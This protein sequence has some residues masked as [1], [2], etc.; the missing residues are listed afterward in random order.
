LAE[1]ETGQLAAFLIAD[2]CLVTAGEISYCTTG[3]RDPGFRREL[4]S[5][6]TAYIVSSRLRRLG[7]DTAAI[8]KVLRPVVLGTG[9]G[10]ASASGET[11]RHAELI[12]TVVFVMI[13]LFTVIGYGLRVM[14][15]MV[16]EK[17]TRMI[18]VLVSSMTPFQ[19]MMGKIAGQ[20]I[21]AV[22]Q[23]VGWVAVGCV[24][25][26]LGQAAGVLGNI[27]EILGVSFVLWFIIFLCLGYLFFSGWLS[28]VGAVV[29]SQQEAAPLMVPV[30]ALFSLSFLVGMVVVEDPSSSLARGL[31]FVP[32]LSPAMMIMRL[33]FSEVP[34]W[35]PA[36]A[37]ILLAGTA[38][39]IIWIGS[40]IFR[41]GILMQGKRPTVSEIVRWAKHG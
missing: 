13:L 2:T 25:L 18:E 37:A 17:S 11:D 34:A 41:V 30:I 23:L 33:R 1:I 12:A 36:L 31:S 26:V 35:E 39:L 32:P 38:V 3:V 9:H 4:Q 24:V 5:H 19:I 15:G 6:L 28:W 22:V 14:R 21:A 10:G 27:A 29:N 7:L 8:G 16:E 20:G 40:R